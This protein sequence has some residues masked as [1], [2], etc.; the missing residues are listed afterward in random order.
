MATGPLQPGRDLIP[1]L[2]GQGFLPVIMIKHH[3]PVLPGPGRLPGMV[4]A[5]ED[6]QQLLVGDNRRVEVD[7]DG[8]GVVPEAVVGGVWLGPARIAYPGADNA[9]ESPELGLRTPESAQTEGGGLGLGGD[10]GIQGRD[11]QLRR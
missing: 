7:L 1:G 5:P 4:A 8:L 9:V 11:G 2:Q 6:V 3:G 10:C